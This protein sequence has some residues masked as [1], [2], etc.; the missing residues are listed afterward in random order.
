MP[1][2]PR[3]RRKKA[4][5]KSA[6][7]PSIDKGSAVIVEWEDAWF[8]VD[9][10]DPVRAACRWMVR[11]IGFLMEMD[12]EKVVLSFEHFKP[13]G[14]YR[15]YQIIPLKMIHSIEE[16]TCSSAYLLHTNL[17]EPEDSNAVS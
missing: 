5:E 13:N 16:L 7:V 17:L 8:E 1:L 2:K 3:Q 6:P 15:S 10:Y 4:A 9:N 11:T 12:A 14:E